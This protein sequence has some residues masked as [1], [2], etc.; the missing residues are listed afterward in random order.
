MKNRAPRQ[1]S[2]RSEPSE[3]RDERNRLQRWSED[4]A[5]LHFLN[6]SLCE[7]L[8][9]EEVVESLAVNL[10]K[11]IRYDIACLFSEKRGDGARL[12]QPEAAGRSP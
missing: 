6:Q 5:R 8:D 9:M 7:S 1:I 3:L 12:L 4:L 10:K 2:R 11:I